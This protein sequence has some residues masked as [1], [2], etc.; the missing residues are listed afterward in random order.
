VGGSIL[1][2]INQLNYFITTQ[3]DFENNNRTIDFIEDKLAKVIVD[4]NI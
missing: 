2:S 1:F 4:G 3:A